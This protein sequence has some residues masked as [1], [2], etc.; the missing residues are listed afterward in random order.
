MKIAAFDL[1]IAKA[2]E[3][4]DWQSQRP[5]GIS[6]AAAKGVIVGKEPRGFDC[7]WSEK[8]QLSR[9]MCQKMVVD[10]QK[11]ANDG[12]VICTVNGAAFDFD[13]LAEES[14]MVAECAE[15]AA[16]HCDFLVMAVCQFGWRVGLD[17]LAAGAG[18]PSKLHEMTLTTG[19]I[20]EDMSGAMAPQLWAQG[21][22]EA[23]LAYLKQ[24]VQATLD[25]ARVA[26]ERGTLRWHSKAGRVWK[27]RL[28]SLHTVTE[29]LQ[30]PRPDTSW[31]TDPPQRGDFTKWMPGGGLPLPL[32]PGLS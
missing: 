21:E 26:L 20:L 2:V 11:I 14:G 17:A 22:H 32:F 28:N 5:L 4:D 1:E 16:N 23:V 31:M 25:V 18:V 13:I 9:E 7:T 29:C 6:C 27:I 10:L 15:L 24:D 19:E 3:G 30:W 8:P 12:Y